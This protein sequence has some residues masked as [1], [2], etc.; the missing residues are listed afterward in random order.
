[1]EITP[2]NGALFL[3]SG[4]AAGAA[5]GTKPPVGRRQ[6]HRDAVPPHSPRAS[7]ESELLR[8]EWT[9]KNKLNQAR[10]LNN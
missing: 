3:A 6:S 7:G 9:I 8:D 1:M 2:A 5:V 10:V 4:P